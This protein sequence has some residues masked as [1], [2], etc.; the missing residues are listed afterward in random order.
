MLKAR[1]TLVGIEQVV[2]EVG[3]KAIDRIY[4]EPF[5]LADIG[6]SKTARPG[7]VLATRVLPFSAFTMTSGAPVA[8]DP[9]LAM[10]FVDGLQEAFGQ[11][12]IIGMLRPKERKQLARNLIGL[13][14]EDPDEMKA[15]WREKVATVWPQAPLDDDLEPVVA[16]LLNVSWKLSQ[17]VVPAASRA[18]GAAWRVPIA[19]KSLK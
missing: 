1:F 2:P 7:L 19:R 6:L 17:T 14:L 15:V 5:L 18:L 11:P 10:L 9:E 4:G 16:P 13:A 3:A 12:A 8:V